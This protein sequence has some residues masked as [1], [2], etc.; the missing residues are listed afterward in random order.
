MLISKRNKKSSS[1]PPYSGGTASGQTANGPHQ[2]P[3]DQYEFNSLPQYTPWNVSNELTE[4]NLQFLS[5]EIQYFPQAGGGLVS[6]DEWKR[7]VEL[8]QMEEGADSNPLYAGS[9]CGSEIGVQPP[10][11]ATVAEANREYSKH[12]SNLLHF[13]QLNNTSQAHGNTTSLNRLALAEVAAAHSDLNSQVSLSLAKT[14]A[15]RAD[16][17]YS[18]SGSSEDEAAVNCHYE[19]T[20][21]MS[22]SNTCQVGDRQSSIYELMESDRTIRNNDSMDAD[23]PTTDNVASATDEQA[24]DNTS[25]ETKMEVCEEDSNTT[26][27]SGMERNDDERAVVS[28]S[29]DEDL[30]ESEVQDDDKGSVHASIAD[31]DDAGPQ[32]MGSKDD[33]DNNEVLC[34]ESLYDDPT[35]LGKYNVSAI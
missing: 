12:S 22:T 18:D 19:A 13:A 34:E 35:C 29:V 1:V 31:R 15:R 32:S 17:E 23:C 4:A 24:L 26:Q 6:L 30:A 9:V 33:G 21:F 2:Q 5:S 7:K 20:Q 10:E 16:L 3:S 25:G 28:H 8:E 11:Y 14:A 27:V